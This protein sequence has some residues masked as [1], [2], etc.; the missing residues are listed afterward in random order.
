M[1]IHFGAPPHECI[2]I[3]ITKCSVFTCSINAEFGNRI[4]VLCSRIGG[5]IG[6][7]Q[8]VAINEQRVHIIIFRVVL[9]YSTNLFDLLGVHRQSHIQSFCINLPSLVIND[10]ILILT[11]RQITSTEMCQM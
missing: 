1:G 8:A 3:Y 5:A 10:H 9:L 2:Y 7:I 11:P 4:N 6:A